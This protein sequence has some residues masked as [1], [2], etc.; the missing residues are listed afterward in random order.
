MQPR[1]IT[2]T[3]G[4]KYIGRFS[5]V[6]PPLASICSDGN[7]RFSA[8]AAICS[9]CFRN[10]TRGR[11]CY[12]VQ[13]SDIKRKSMQCIERGY[14]INLRV[15]VVQHNNVCSRMSRLS[16]LLC[17][18][19]L[20]L[21]LTAETRRT[22]SLLNSLKNK[23]LMV[24]NTLEGM[25]SSSFPTI[26]QQ[27]MYLYFLHCTLPKDSLQIQTRANYGSGAKYGLSSF[28]IRPADLE[29]ILINQTDALTFKHLLSTHPMIYLFLLW[30]ESPKHSIHPLLLRRLF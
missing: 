13:E 19:A 10:Q 12:Q 17:R 27:K 3:C 1:E 2:S 29:T 6:T 5:V 7:S 16:R 21:N 9:S 23:E 20:H 28:L 11:S 24:I 22:A 4:E 8:P 25:G 14:I 26:I 15:K 18:A 30:G